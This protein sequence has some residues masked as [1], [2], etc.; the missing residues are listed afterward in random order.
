MVENSAQKCSLRRPAKRARMSTS[1]HALPR[2]Y[3]IL[4]HAGAGN[5]SPS[6]ESE[7]I[8]A[9]KN[10]LIIA[11]DNLL[12]APTR[13]RLFPYQPCGTA[14]SACVAAVMSMEM[15]ECC[16]AGHGSN[17]NINGEVECDASVMDGDFNGFAVETLKYTKL[18]GTNT[19]RTNLE[20][21]RRM[22]NKKTICGCLPNKQPD[23]RG[24]QK[25]LNNQF[26]PAN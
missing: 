25:P 1:A 7:Y 18:P 5:H 21:T 12:A 23:G 6:R 15:D 10:A 22:T 14:L 16:N 17:L 24:P 26:R 9:V 20:F 3:C 13:T 2:R 4:V 8:K 19:T 11:R